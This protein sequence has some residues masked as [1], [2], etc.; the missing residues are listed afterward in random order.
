V[1]GPHPSSF[2]R[3][4]RKPRRFLE[5]LRRGI[6]P[7][8]VGEPETSLVGSTLLEVSHPRQV[9]QSAGL[10]GA[11]WVKWGSFG[12]YGV[13]LHLICTTNGVPIS[14]ELTP[15]NDVAELTL[16]EE[17]LEE[18]ALGDGVARRLLGDLAYRS[19]DLEGTLSE[20]VGILLRTERARRRPGLGRRIEIALIRASS[21]SSASAKRR[22]RHSSG[23]PPGSRRRSAPTPLRV[24]G[25][26][27][28]GSSSRAHQGAV[29]LNLATHI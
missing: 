20:E 4:V 10:E 9:G 5:P 11:A 26:P 17:L 27:P 24:F 13:K 15:A 12:V 16:T 25:R 6:L 23:W 3:R 22:R 19:E 7:E 8:L 14:Y 28:A 29:G 21:G 1:V 2:D 18:A